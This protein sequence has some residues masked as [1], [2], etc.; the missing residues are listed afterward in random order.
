MPYFD[1]PKAARAA[2]QK[3][4][5]LHRNA[6]WRSIGFPNLIRARAVYAE[7]CKQRRIEKWKQEERRRTPFADFLDIPPGVLKPKKRR[8]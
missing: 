6:F 2:F 8:R 1:D 3:M 4:C 5:S 7:N